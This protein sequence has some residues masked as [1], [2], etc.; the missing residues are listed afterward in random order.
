M[1]RKDY[2][3]IAKAF[4]VTRPTGPGTITRIQWARDREVIANVLE[5]DNPRFN[6]EQFYSATEQDNA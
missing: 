4:A 6:R 2:V 1:T 3:K 5:T